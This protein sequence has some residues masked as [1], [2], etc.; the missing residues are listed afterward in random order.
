MSYE[1]IFHINVDAKAH[2]KF[3]LS[4]LMHTRKNKTDLEFVFT[5]PD[6]QEHS[7]YITRR[8]LAKVLRIGIIPEL[9]DE[10]NY[11]L[12]HPYEF[13]NDRMRIINPVENNL[14]SD[15]VW[16]KMKK[17]IDVRRKKK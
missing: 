17:R 3:S 4:D 14:C 2:A 8:K 6:K 5:T 10:V 13:K 16:P 9:R 1:R 11:H 15:I 12:N 7:V